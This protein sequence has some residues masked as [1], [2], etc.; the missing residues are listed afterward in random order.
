ML[1]LRLEGNKRSIAG[2]ENEKKFSIRRALIYRE[3]PVSKRPKQT[4]KGKTKT[5]QF[6]YLAFFGRI[7]LRPDLNLATKKSCHDN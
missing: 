5:D 2:Q 1:T 6:W 3:K 7:V 4:I